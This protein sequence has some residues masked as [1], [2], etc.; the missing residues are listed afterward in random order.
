MA[1]LL[2]FVWVMFTNIV[3]TLGNLGLIYDINKHS[4]SVS[5]I[6]SSIKGIRHAFA[7]VPG[8]IVG[9]D[10]HHKLL[11][12]VYYSTVYLMI[13]SSCFGMVFVVYAHIRDH[14][15]H[16]GWICR[17]L[18]YIGYCYISFVCYLTFTV[19]FAEKEIVLESSV[20]SFSKYFLICMMITAFVYNYGVEEF[21]IDVTTVLGDWSANS[22]FL[23]LT[24]F[25]TRYQYSLGI[26]IVLQIIEC[27]RLVRWM[28]FRSLY[29]QDQLLTSVYSQTLFVSIV[30][31]LPYFIPFLHL[32]WM[33]KINKQEFSSLFIPTADHPSYKRMYEERGHRVVQY[34]NLVVSFI[35]YSFMDD[36]GWSPSSPLIPQ[37]EV[38]SDIAEDSDASEYAWDTSLCTRAGSDADDENDGYN[39]CDTHEV[40]FTDS[41]DERVDVDDGVTAEQKASQRY[42]MELQRQIEELEKIPRPSGDMEHLWER[43]QLE[44][45][46]YRRQ[47]A[48]QMENMIRFTTNTQ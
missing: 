35:R 11:L 21:E 19:I 28:Q 14:L 15:A 17:K 13:L 30:Y 32:F 43:I 39:T 5:V 47:F 24:K 16:F 25:L 40:F 22:F 2:I 41:D 31:L 27:N 9:H 1:T 45:E 20:V 37:D 48:W 6:R 42:G 12:V 18:V 4:T 10:L 46:L 7:A 8:Y 26:L 44:N 36:E 29:N 38:W 3:S 23:V 33:Y 34:K